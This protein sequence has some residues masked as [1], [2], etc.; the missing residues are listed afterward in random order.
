VAEVRLVE[1]RRDP[2]PDQAGR[3]GRGAVHQEPQEGIQPHRCTGRFT[4]LRVK[5]GP[6]RHTGKG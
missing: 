5:L 4:R 1:V 6:A 2:K 3:Q